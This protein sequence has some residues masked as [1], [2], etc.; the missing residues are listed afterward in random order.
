MAKKSR[1]DQSREPGGY[2]AL[3]WCVIDSQAYQSLS[4]PAVAL[5]IELARQRQGGDNGRYLLSGRYLATRGWRSRDVIDRARRELLDAKLIYQT[6]QGHRPN[7]ASWFALTWYSLDKLPG[8]DAG[9]VEGFRRGM[10]N[11][12]K[13]STPAPTREALFEKWR[14]HGKTASTKI[15]ML[16]PAGGLEKP[17]IDPAGGLESAARPPGDGAIRALLPPLSSPAS[18]H[19]LDLPFCPAESLTA[20]SKAVKATTPAATT[21]PWFEPR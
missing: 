7:K 9:A 21:E 4:Y 19:P 5:L 8:Y 10:Y 1:V 18:G 12:F 6:V 20:G 17:A 3:P 15:N 13:P 16:S 2:C 14:G 11:T